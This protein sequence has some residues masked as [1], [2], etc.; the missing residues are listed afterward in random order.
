MVWLL[1]LCVNSILS[2]T[3]T[4]TS[5]PLLSALITKSLFCPIINCRG[6]FTVTGNKDDVVVM[7]T[8]SA[9]ILKLYGLLMSAFD[10][11]T[12]SSL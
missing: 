12:V 6:I 9:G 2:G 10:A 3:S 7:V 4:I 1:L 8:F 5:P 11:P